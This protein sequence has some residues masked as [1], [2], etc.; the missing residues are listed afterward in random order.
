MTTARMP[1]VRRPEPRSPSAAEGPNVLL[2]SVCGIDDVLVL[3]NSETA[4]PVLFEERVDSSIT[5]SVGVQLVAP[6]LTVVL[7]KRGVF[8]APVPEATVDEDGHSCSR[9]HEVSPASHERDRAAV[10]AVPEAS[11]MQ[12]P[13]QRQFGL[14]VTLWLSPESL[15]HGVVEWLRSHNPKVLR[16]DNGA[17]TGP[18]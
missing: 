5:F 15:A 4:P 18:H 6:P 1:F 3:P 17:V 12:L 11:P 9:E 13:A 2:H 10:D 7:R 16:G 8:R 14:G